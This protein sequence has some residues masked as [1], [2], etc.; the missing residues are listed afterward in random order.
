M[1]ASSLRDSLQNL[2]K[3]ASILEENLPSNQGLAGSP[4]LSDDKRDE[5]LPA[6]FLLRMA[7]LL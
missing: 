5:L 1:N 7:R 4:S 6:L 3:Y 2:V